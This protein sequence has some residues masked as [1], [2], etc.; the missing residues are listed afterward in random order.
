M[1]ASLNL[2]SQLAPFRL[3]ELPEDI[4]HNIGTFW[5]DFPFGLPTSSLNRDLHS[6]FSTPPDVSRRA[7]SRFGGARNALIRDCTRAARDIRVT[8]ALIRR[9]DVAKGDLEA[10]F[11]LVCSMGDIARA[12]SLLA[13]GAD[14]QPIQQY[15]T[16]DEAARRHFNTNINN[17]L[18]SYGPTD[19]PARYFA[20]VP[21]CWNGH[22]EIV[23]LI[24]GRDVKRDVLPSLCV[25]SIWLNACMYGRLEIAT[26]L[27]GSGLVPHSSIR[28]GL[29]L[30]SFRG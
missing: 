25:R 9:C 3:L 24:F 22:H 5:Q 29:Q 23:R 8:E 20:L 15:T 10:A 2:N 11:I 13:G 27:L 4:L 12:Q 6:A 26:M 18:V 30:A 7:I 14:I 28:T 21:A 17:I 1:T 16:V 19:A